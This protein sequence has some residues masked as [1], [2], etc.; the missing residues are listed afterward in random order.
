MTVLYQTCVT[1]YAMW[2][3]CSLRSFL[4]LCIHPFSLQGT[5]KPRRGSIKWSS[6]KYGN[7]DSGTGVR[8]GTPAPA[9]ALAGAASSPRIGLSFLSYKENNTEFQ[10][11]LQNE[12]SKTLADTSIGYEHRR[13][14]IRLS[15]SCPRKMKVVAVTTTNGQ[16]QKTPTSLRQ[17]L[18]G[19]SR[20]PF[21]YLIFS[22]PYTKHFSK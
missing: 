20:L 6:P 14:F 8:T 18:C 17:V 3:G 5:L 13:H 2:T 9:F 19:H 4:L 22:L 10:V 16:C 21:S 11:Q 15:A 7:N 1:T 12:I